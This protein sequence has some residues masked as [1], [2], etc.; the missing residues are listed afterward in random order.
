[1]KN[2]KRV[3]CIVLTVLLVFGAIPFSGLVTLAAD[4]TKVNT[5]SVTVNK[6]YLPKDGMQCIPR[7][8]FLTVSSGDVYKRS[9]LA[10]GTWYDDVKDPNNRSFTGAR[11]YTINQ[12]LD[13]Y[14][15]YD[16]EAGRSYYYVVCFAI[17]DEFKST[18][19]FAS[20]DNVVKFEFK[21][22]TKSEY[23]Y[24]V[25]ATNNRGGEIYVI[26]K[27]N[28]SGTRKYED[29]KTVHACVEG[30]NSNQSNTLPPYCNRTA[31]W[32]TTYYANFDYSREWIG[33]FIV[34]NGQETSKF[35]AG[36]TY[37]LILTY[38]AKKGYKFSS[39]C[40]FMFSTLAVQGYGKD[41]SIKAEPKSISV[42]DGRTKVIVTFEFTIKD[43]DYISYLTLENDA[44]TNL[45]PRSGAYLNKIGDKVYVDIS[46]QP[47]T[48]TFTNEFYQAL[49]WV[50]DKGNLITYAPQNGLCSFT[51]YFSVEDSKKY[52][53]TDNLEFE[54]EGIDSKYYWT[55]YELREDN[56]VVYV[57]YYFISDYHLEPTV[58]KSDG[59][60]FQC[61]SYESF[62]FAL[63][64]DDIEYIELCSVDSALPF[65]YYENVNQVNSKYAPAIVLEGKHDLKITGQNYFKINQVDTT[66]YYAYDDFVFIPSDGS[67]DISGDG[68][69][70]V[71]FGQPDRPF[72]MFFNKGTLNVKDASLYAEGIEKNVYPQVINNR[73]KLNIYS[74]NFNSKNMFLLENGTVLLNYGSE[75]FIDGGT[76][77]ATYGSGAVGGNFGLMINSD[78]LSL[79]INRGT[80]KALGIK[81]PNDTIPLTTYAPYQTHSVQLGDVPTDIYGLKQD[82]LYCKIQIF[83]LIRDFNVRINIPTSGTY[84][85]KTV[86]IDTDK[87]ILVGEPVWYCDYEEMDINNETFVKGCEYEVEITLRTV[88]AN[89]TIRE[90]IKS[91]LKAYV[92][93][94][95]A[96][97]YNS[98]ENAKEIVIN[99]EFGTCYDAITKAQVEGITTPQEN[100]TPDKYASVVSEDTLLYGIPT[101]AIT[102]YKYTDS[103]SDAVPMEAGETFTSGKYKYYVQIKLQTKGTRVFNYNEWGYVCMDGYIDGERC[104]V[105]EVWVSQSQINSKCIY[106]EQ[107]FG[108]CPN[109]EVESVYIWNFEEPWA[110]EVPSYTLDFDR[111]QCKEEIGGGGYDTV[112]GS[113]NITE[114]WWYNKNG[115]FWYDWTDGR[116]MYD[117]DPFIEGHEY[118]VVINLECF[119]GNEF[120]CSRYYETYVKVYINGEEV[121]DVEQEGSFNIRISKTFTC[122]S[123]VDIYDITGDK[124][125]DVRDIVRSKRI[126]AKVT[127]SFSIN[128][129]FDENG[130]VDSWDLVTIKK[131]L[132][133]Y[134]KK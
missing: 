124:N 77:D 32:I 75:T 93:G 110:G 70:T 54:I 127:S 30:P 16:F 99:Y 49:N 82:D 79:S 91:L 53:F 28:V 92:N 46:T 131:A 13:K 6:D 48:G 86:E 18:H 126:A 20:G 84:P 71:Q 58:G 116:F 29:I 11:W 90:P 63:E 74:G 37:K 25:Y 105:S 21:N 114:L 130:Y 2:F 133:R 17:K 64:H 66:A 101:N 94:K 55:E 7:E 22:L 106:L 23:K 3:L 78:T 113:G 8:D 117:F 38:T 41:S 26:L 57:T 81:L 100:D 85:S 52:R 69:L 61:T 134:N 27:F 36:N 4:K 34:E 72:A 96:D 51:Y 129:D 40:S 5:I 76:F 73:G 68:K 9:G 44:G 80:F 121:E 83:E 24:E 19:E 104:N 39:D 103:K 109:V 115:I 10:G 35:K 87:Y 107:D 67:L 102:W 132:F 125:F 14:V 12:Y 98:V 120:S 43:Y 118:E 42:E 122:K 123:A 47:Y 45:L 62:K 95:K 59:K 1:M 50:D 128:P 88:M 89:G 15:G 33:D 112:C 31:P 119:G 97:T 60:R 56:A 111:S 108:S 65:R